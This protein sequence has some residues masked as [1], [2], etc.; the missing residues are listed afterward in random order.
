V[1]N[2]GGGVYKSTGLT[3]VSPISYRTSFY[4]AHLYI[5]GGYGKC[6][7]TYSPA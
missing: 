2:G 7:L 6:V 1:G 5:D 4:S 3:I